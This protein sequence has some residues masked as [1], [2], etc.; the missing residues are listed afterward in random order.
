VGLVLLIACANVANLLLARASAR[1][2]EIAIR[3]ALGAGRGQLLRQ[4]LT[5]SLLLALLG[6]ALGIVLAYWSWDLLLSFM[7]RVDLPIGLQG[8]GLDWKTMGYTFALSLLTGLIFGL[9]PALEASRRDVVSALKDESAGI[10]AGKGRLRHGLVIAQVSLSLLLLIS[11]GLLLRSLFNAHAVNTGFVAQGVWLGSFDLFP[12]G[13]T[14]ETGR[15]FQKQLLERVAAVPGVESASL[16]RRVPLGFG[17]SSGTSIEVEGYQPGKE[18]PPF[19]NYNNVAPN[20]FRTM[21]IE[22]LQGRDFTAQDLKGT[23]GVTVVNETMAQRYWSGRQAVGGR[24]RFGNDW[25]TVAGVVRTHK[26]RALN[27]APRPFMY[28][29]LQQWYRPDTTLHVRTAGDPAALT[30]SIRAVVRGLDANLPLFNV[31]TLQNH[32]GAATFTQRLGGY[33]LAVFGALALV[34]AA[35]G[36]Y[37]VMSFS[38][39]QR[40]REIGIRMA[41]GAGR[42]NIL[43]MVLREGVVLVAAGLGI[44]LTIALAAANAIK[45]LLLNV[46]A[47]DPLTF[48]A[49]PLL[50]AGVALLATYVPARRATRVDPLVALRYE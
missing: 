31:T 38:V 37:G 5:E 33:L 3:I 40:A 16:A 25:L 4:L 47:R 24:V 14:P 7:P 26:Y 23:P 41:L 20:Y 11:A 43:L 45:A 21:G 27:E 42:P 49:V 48:A 13:Y 19:V 28:V 10:A 1:R 34:L 17:G 12:N 35:I 6:G 29:P 36:V 44:G 9:A 46:S 2:R 8:S 22:V 30:A 32:I 18:E 39:N 15:E 50:L